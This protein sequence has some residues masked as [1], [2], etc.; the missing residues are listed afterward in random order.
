MG[1]PQ[2]VQKVRSAM[3]DNL[4]LLRGDDSIYLRAVFGIV[5]NGIKPEPESCWHARQWHRVMSD[6]GSLEVYC[7]SPQRHPPLNTTSPLLVC[8]TYLDPSAAMQL[9]VYHMLGSSRS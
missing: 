9:S 1:V 7:T 8:G 6:G 2:L 3:S 5:V 4:R